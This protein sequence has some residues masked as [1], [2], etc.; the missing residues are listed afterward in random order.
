MADEPLIP[1]VMPEPRHRSG[2]PLVN[3]TP[4][5]P[6]PLNIGYNPDDPADLW[7]NITPLSPAEFTQ[8][9]AA[10]AGTSADGEI[11]WRYNSDPPP[12]YDLVTETS[13]VGHGPRG[14]PAQP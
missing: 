9:A 8:G 10:T 3:A 1:Y 5:H 7:E 2:Q 6:E 12:L 11:G 13:D 4:R 14:L